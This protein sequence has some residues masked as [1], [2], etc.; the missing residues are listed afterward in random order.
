MLPKWLSPRVW[1][2]V[3]ELPDFRPSFSV[4]VG[5]LEGVVREMFGAVLRT[6]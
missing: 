3:T 4:D 5:K 2:L 1:K 6:R